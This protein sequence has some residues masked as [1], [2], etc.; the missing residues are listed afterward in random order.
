VPRISTKGNGSQRCAASTVGS[1]FFAW[2]APA[3]Q[4]QRQ[5]LH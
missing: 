5:S 3:T 2:G 4:Q 1:S